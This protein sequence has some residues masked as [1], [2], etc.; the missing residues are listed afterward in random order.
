MPSR[1]ELE[2]QLQSAPSDPRASD[3]TAPDLRAIGG[4]HDTRA[5]LA[6]FQVHRPEEPCAEVAGGDVQIHTRVRPMSGDDRGQER[7]A[8]LDVEPGHLGRERGGIVHRATHGAQNVGLGLQS[9]VAQLAAIIVVRIT[10]A[11]QPGE[12][13]DQVRVQ[14]STLQK[15]GAARSQRKHHVVLE[16]QHL[17]GL[18]RRI[19]AASPRA[20][21]GRR[22]QRECLQRVRGVQ[23]EQ[24][25]RGPIAALAV[26]DSERTQVPVA[27]VILRHF[28]AARMQPS[29]IFDLDPRGGALQKRL[30]AK[31]DVTAPQAR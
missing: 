6:T 29:H 14:L 3:L 31:L 23:Q 7:S 4:G 10:D 30:T 15:N 1:R 5:P 26:P 21:G 25:P 11:A 12:W 22:R 8:A 13:F 20:V 2:R 17:G 19:E 27:P 24:K 18:A 9:E 28:R 16:H